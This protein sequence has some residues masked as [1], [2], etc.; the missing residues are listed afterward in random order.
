M[1]CT[2]RD[3]NGQIDQEIAVQLRVGCDSFNTA[4]PCTVCGKLC[5]PDGSSVSNR[6][7]HATFLA[8]DGVRIENRDKNGVVQSSF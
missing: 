4:H 8:K 5:W 3:C 2:E 7:G 1:K 6:Q